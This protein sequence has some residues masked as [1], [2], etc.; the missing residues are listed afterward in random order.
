MLMNRFICTFFQWALT[1]ALVPVFSLL[2]VSCKDDDKDPGP[3]P[4][5]EFTITALDPDAGAIGDIVTVFGSG[6]NPDRTQN[7]VFFTDGVE[8][9]PILPGSTDSTLIVEVPE[10]GEEG[11]S[12]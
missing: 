8:A 3:E 10:G 5:P 11:P 7:R 4:D 6:F 12:A 2:V 1:F 9:T